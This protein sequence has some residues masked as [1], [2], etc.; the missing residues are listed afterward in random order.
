MVDSSY[1][2]FSVSRRVASPPERVSPVT[3]GVLV[4]AAAEAARVGTVVPVDSAARQHGPLL[5]EAPSSTAAL[6]FSAEPKE[7]TATWVLKVQSDLADLRIRRVSLGEGGA[8]EGA[9]YF[10]PLA[11]P[12]AAPA[13]DSEAVHAPY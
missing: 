13:R 8:T 6:F 7:L 9:F 1:T 4:V 3:E 11:S 2:T 10:L 12:V 5:V